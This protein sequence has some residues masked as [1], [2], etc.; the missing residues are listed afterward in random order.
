MGDCDMLKCAVCIE[1]LKDGG[2]RR[3]PSDSAAPSGSSSRDPPP[4]LE[5]EIELM[6]PPLDSSLAS[7][8]QVSYSWARIETDRVEMSTPHLTRFLPQTQRKKRLEGRDSF[9]MRC[10]LN[11]GGRL[12]VAP[13]S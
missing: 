2:E 7:A 3:A 13:A 10:F 9:L 4:S 6:E 1:C 11:G 5:D 8:L 12:Y